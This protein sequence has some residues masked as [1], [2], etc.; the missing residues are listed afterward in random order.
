MRQMSNSYILAPRDLLIGVGTSGFTAMTGI[1]LDGTTEK[2]AIKYYP[3]ATSPIT[4]IAIRLAVT[5]NPGSFKIG[6]FANTYAVN[7]NGSPDDASQLSGWS[8]TFDLAVT[9]WTSL[10]ALAT[11]SGNLVNGTPVWIVI[12]WDSDVCDVSNYIQLQQ[13]NTFNYGS[14]R[15]LQRH[16]NG[17]DW[18]TTAGTTTFPVVV[19]KHADG[20]Y[21][22]MPITAS[23]AASA[24]PDIFV[25]TGV[26]QVQGFRFKCGSQVKV[27]GLS[28]YLTKANTPNDLIWSIYEGDTLKYSQ[29]E[30]VANVLNGTPSVVWFDTPVLLAADTYLYI[31]ASQ[32]G[33]SGTNDYDLRCWT[34]DAAYI[35]ASLPADMRFVYGNGS[36]PSALTVATTEIPWCFPIISDP[37]LDLDMVAGNTSIYPPLDNWIMR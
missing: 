29:T 6:V 35:D 32:T 5:G 4:D 2:V 3:S 14:N 19:I 30:L 15:I 21:T 24:A 26:S 22:G 7:S 33:T 1:I 27:Q 17:T 31:I 37:A 28:Y 23:I 36:T 11:N 16:Y 34:I 25:N 12:V 9:G 13:F 8:T 10:L 20:T 18:V